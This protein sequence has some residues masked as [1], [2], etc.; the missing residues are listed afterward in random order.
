MPRIYER[1]WKYR[2]LQWKFGNFNIFLVPVKAVCPCHVLDW[3]V[4]IHCQRLPEQEGSVVSTDR[5]LARDAERNDVDEIQF[6][7]KIK[8]LRDK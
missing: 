7:V 1:I 2:K 6:G 8:N 3:P 4:A 5:S